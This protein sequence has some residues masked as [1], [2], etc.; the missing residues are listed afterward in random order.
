MHPERRGLRGAA[1]A[2]GGGS[3]VVGWLA[4]EVYGCSGGFADG[5]V[6]AGLAEVAAGREREDGDREGGT[7]RQRHHSDLMPERTEGPGLP[8]DAYAVVRETGRH[9]VLEHLPMHR[10]LH[11]RRLLGRQQLPG[12]QPPQ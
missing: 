11:E 12:P 7:T 2:A 1:R 6:Y 4:E 10:R 5:G 8:G 3:W 9:P